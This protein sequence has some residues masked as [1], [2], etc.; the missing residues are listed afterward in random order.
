MHKTNFKKLAKTLIKKYG[1]DN[2]F[3]I[4][5]HQGIKIIYSDFSSWLGLYTCIGN[6]KT[7]FI[8]IKLP[9]LSKRIVCS[10]ELGHSQQSF[11]EAISIFMKVKNFCPKQA[12]LNKKQ[13]NLLQL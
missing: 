13:T 11:N 12:K 7:I 5:E 3:K 1:T 10:H 4:A 2:P 9:Y 8:N 6:E